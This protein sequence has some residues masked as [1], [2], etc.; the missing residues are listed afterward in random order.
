[1]SDLRKFFGNAKVDVLIYVLK[2]KKFNTTEMYRDLNKGEFC[3]RNNLM[4]LQKTGLII[5]DPVPQNGKIFFH[6]N[7]DFEGL[8][9]LNYLVE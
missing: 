3:I 7:E 5:K 9:K 1:M 8:E 4:K 6:I 2:H